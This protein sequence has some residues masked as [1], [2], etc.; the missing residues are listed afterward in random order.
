MD[1]LAIAGLTVV[2]VILVIFAW[3]QIVC[4]WVEQNAWRELARRKG[5][6]YRRRRTLGVPR[7]GRIVGTWRGRECSVSTY[8]ALGVALQMRVVLSV[9]NRSDGTLLA[10]GQPSDWRDLEPE[11]RETGPALEIVESQPGDLAH[12]ALVS[13]GLDDR[14]REIAR[15][16]RTYGYRIEVSGHA[17]RFEWPFRRFSRLDIDPIVRTLTAL[18]DALCDTAEAV[19]QNV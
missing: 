17:L 8:K 18:L 13:T 15:E 12:K 16:R 11:R 19:E 7:G 5:M 1:Y 3:P 4:P 2:L 9:D 14:I 6:R 10:L